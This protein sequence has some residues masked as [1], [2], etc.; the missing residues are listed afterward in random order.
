MLMQMSITQ[1]SAQRA[2]PHT[3]GASWMSPSNSALLATRVGAT[4]RPADGLKRL[5]HVLGEVGQRGLCI[6]KEQKRC[7][8]KQQDAWA[9]FFLCR[10]VWEPGSS[11]IR[12][13]GTRVGLSCNSLRLGFPELKNF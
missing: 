8:P 11:C 2:H 12:F 1:P 7:Q 4:Q 5:G 3:N 6:R 13:S 9:W 10:Q